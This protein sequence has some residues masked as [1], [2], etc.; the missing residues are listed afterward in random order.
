MI[1]SPKDLELEHPQIVLIT[2]FWLKQLPVMQ[3]SVAHKTS[4]F[5]K[6]I[7]IAESPC[8]A[9]LSAL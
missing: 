3:F 5:L 9:A 8:T 7:D 1:P 2:L 4:T 6:H